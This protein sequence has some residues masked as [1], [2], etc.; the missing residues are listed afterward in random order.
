MTA[1]VSTLAVVATAAALAPASSAADRPPNIVFLYADDLGYG[2][3][4]VNGNPHAVTPNID[5]LAK[6]SVNFTNGYCPAPQCSP[7][8]AS[9]LTGQSPARLH[10]T[11][12]LRDPKNKS[13]WPEYKGWSLPV[14]K[15]EISPDAVTL[16]RLLKDRGYRSLH[17][18]KWHVGEKPSDPV[19]LGFDSALGTW[20]WSWPKSWFAP[21]RIETLKDAPPGEYLD[22]RL[23][24]EAVA[25]MKQNRDKPFYLNVWFY[26]PHKPLAAPGDDVAAFT[27][28]G[29]EEGDKASPSATYEAMKTALDRNV[30]RILDALDDLGIAEN[31]LVVF[32]SDNGA[33]APF[34]SNAPFRGNKKMFLEGGI[35][36][37]TFF[38]WKGRFAPRDEPT[39]MTHTDFLP[40]FIE[41]AGGST[42]GLALDGTS[43][44]GVLAGSD[45]LPERP[46]FWHFPQLNYEGKNAIFPQG[47]VRLGKWKLIQPYVEPDRK[48]QLYD[49][50][51][52]PGESR[53][54][55]DQHPD[56][57]ADLRTK[58]ADFLRCADAQMPKKDGRLPNWFAE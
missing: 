19:G 8:R 13:F 44:A 12:F 4:G 7:S 10:I 21:Y 48:P 15:T 39:P 41:L 2:D 38:R 6:E 51:A 18:G 57:V 33:V 56:I 26:A 24:E 50:E 37:P 17:L 16:P 53:N 35:R 23:A 11:D 40:T 45:P 31:T 3:L 29:F 46:L 54:L 5:R 25:F 14:Q 32:S 1:V 28:K 20:P 36:M 55:A 47:V 43:L 22:N 58:L 49:L 52:D 42:D 9:I 30:G 27:A 34:G